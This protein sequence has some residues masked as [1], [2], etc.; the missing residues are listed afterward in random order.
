MTDYLLLKLSEMALRA[1]VG[2][3]NKKWVCVGY[4]KTLDGIWE[5]YFMNDYPDRIYYAH[6]DD[7]GSCLVWFSE[8][9]VVYH[10]VDDLH[11]AMLRGE[12]MRFDRLEFL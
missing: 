4:V 6:R 8:G 12:Y 9:T 11:E 7:S 5:E 3:P 1:M 10:Q 2:I